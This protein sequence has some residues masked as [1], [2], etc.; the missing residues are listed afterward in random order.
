MSVLDRY[1]A[2]HP[3]VMGYQSLFPQASASVITTDFSKLEKH[4]MQQLKAR[5]E[6]KD[7][8]QKA[9][10]YGTSIH[11]MWDSWYKQG[12]DVMPR[13]VYSF[14]PAMNNKVITTRVQTLAEL[15]EVLDN[16]PSFT[17]ISCVQ[18][19]KHWLIHKGPV[20]AKSSTQHG[21]WKAISVKRLP[22]PI[23]ML[24]VI[25]PLMG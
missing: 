1:P 13:R 25:D 5:P 3:Q 9:M 2:L 15:Q 11:N 22:K 12:V 24:L 6:L 23:R 14:D 19:G 20:S 7:H 4:V 18:D 21:K 16:N 17:H 8:Y 10:Y